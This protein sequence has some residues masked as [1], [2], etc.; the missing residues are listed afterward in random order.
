MFINFTETLGITDIQQVELKDGID[1]L[2][3]HLVKIELYKGIEGVV[4][5]K[6]EK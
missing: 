5:V 3:Y 2:G 1:T 6:L 4:K